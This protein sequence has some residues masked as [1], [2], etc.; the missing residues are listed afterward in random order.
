MRAHGGRVRAFRAI[1]AGDEDAAADAFAEALAAARNYGR[2]GHLA[3]VL[4]DYGVWLA[5]SGR[6]DE[7]EPLLDEAQELFERMGA[8]RWLERIEAARSPAKVTA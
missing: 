5:E 7:A 6:G 8:V 2:A 1:S 3:P 4:A